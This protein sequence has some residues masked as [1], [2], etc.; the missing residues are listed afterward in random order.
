MMQTT[1]ATLDLER[2]R[3][4]FS[5]ISAHTHKLFE[6]V[7]NI[8]RSSFSD[9]GGSK[10]C[11]CFTAIC[12]SKTG[13]SI[14]V[15]TI[16][17]S[18]ALPTNVCG[19]RLAA[20]AFSLR[21]LATCCAD[22]GYDVARALRSANLENHP[23]LVAITGWGQPTDKESAYEAGFQRLFEFFSRLTKDAWQRGCVASDVTALRNYLNLERETRLELATPTLARSCSTN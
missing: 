2:W 4:L 6:R 3:A 1:G 14:L 17:R 18:L 19:A 5:P 8:I 12:G 22:S 16:E 11:I 10:S 9:P 20:P 21:L 15:I 23:T 7:C 13:C